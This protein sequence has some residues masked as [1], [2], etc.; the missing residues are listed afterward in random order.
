MNQKT[1]RIKGFQIRLTENQ[2]GT[3]QPDSGDVAKVA[4]IDFFLTYSNLREIYTYFIDKKYLEACKL[5]AYHEDLVVP[6]AKER[7]L[8]FFLISWLLVFRCL[9]SEEQEIDALNPLH[10]FICG[11]MGEK[12]SNEDILILIIDK[13]LFFEQP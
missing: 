7:I 1:I 5:T 4:G 9:N 12:L 8:N 11:L 10:Q 3:F 13:G 2:A 6:I